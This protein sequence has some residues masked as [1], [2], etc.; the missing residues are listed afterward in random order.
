MLTVH[1]LESMLGPFRR[2]TYETPWEQATV[3]EIVH[4]HRLP[5]WPP[6]LPLFVAVN[7]KKVR[8]LA[9]LDDRPPDGSFVVVAPQFQGPAGFAIPL[10]GKVVIAFV[11]SVFAFGIGRSLARKQKP[12][13]RGS[14]QYGFD[15]VST[16]QGQGNKKPKGYGRMVVGGQVAQAALIAPDGLIDREELLVVVSFGE[17]RWHSIGGETG[18]EAGEWDPSPF[19]DGGGPVGITVNGI[20]IDPQSVSLRMGTLTQSVFP[21]I[22]FGSSV[23][24]VGATLNDQTNGDAQAPVVQLVTESI[25]R[26]TCKLVFPSGLYRVIGGNSQPVAVTFRV[27]WRP[28]A[29]IGQSGG[30][31]TAEPDFTVAPAQAT[32][33]RFAFNKSFAIPVATPNGVD[34]RL[35]RLTAKVPDPGVGDCVWQQVQHR[36]DG[37]FAHPGHVMA[38][39]RFAA[40]ETTDTFGENIEVRALAEMDRVTLWDPVL[41]HSTRSYYLQ[42]ELHDPADPFAGK[43]TFAPGRNPAWIAHRMLTEPEGSLQAVARD[44]TIRMQDVF[45]FATWCDQDDGAGQPMFTCDILF[46]E[47]IGGFDAL[48]RVCQVAR[49]VPAVIGDEIRFFYDFR[50]AHGHVTARKV[51]GQ[52]A[53]SSM[54][55]FR[56]R[57]LDYD[58]RPALTHV[59]FQSED[60]GFDWVLIPI[61]DPER[62]HNKPY[63]LDFRPIVEDTIRVQGMVRAAQVQRETL[64][65]INILRLTRSEF[66]GEGGPETFAYELNDIVDVHSE[67]FRPFGTDATSYAFRGRNDA[68]N[69]TL[70]LDREVTLPASAQVQGVNHVGTLKTVAITTGAGTYPAGTVLTLGA[71][72]TIHAEGTAVVIGETAKL[73]RPYI[74]IEIEPLALNVRRY[75]GV[76]WQPAAFDV[77]GPGLPP[78]SGPT[79]DPAPDGTLTPGVPEVQT[80]TLR[81]RHEGHELTWQGADGGTGRRV[82]VFARRAGSA[83]SRLELLGA[84]SGRALVTPYLEPHRDYEMVV[85]PQ[86]GHGVYRSPEGTTP[87]VVRAQEFPSTHVATP[88]GF[89]AEIVA[90]GIRF[91]WE[92]VEHFDLHDYEI[93]VGPKWLGGQVVLRTGVPHALLTDPWSSDGQQFML[94]A[95]TRSGMVSG[96]PAYVTV[97]FDRPHDAAAH[98]QTEDIAAALAGTLSAGLAYQTS[99]TRYVELTGPSGI[100]TS[101]QINA[102][103]VGRFWWSFYVDG[104]WRDVATTIG[105]LTHRIGD[106]EAAWRLVGGRPASVHKRGHD[107]DRLISDATNPIR[108]STRYCGGAADSPGD[109]GRLVP[110]IRFELPGSGWTA[111]RP[112]RSQWAVAQKAEGRVRLNRAGAK[113]DVRL[114]RAVIAAAV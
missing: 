54:R 8:E 69:L 44:Y 62:R 36:V 49:C 9:E 31:W 107:F 37:P 15:G 100:Y 91:D 65:Q 84:A 86:D 60:D 99:P 35:R 68:T 59:Q 21:E 45:D 6:G 16:T 30:G 71:T 79:A 81:R 5:E 41:G 18:G 110:E 104:W 27:E 33:G 114:T 90:G 52:L 101:P 25:D 73:C 78:P 96:R 106:G 51:V 7:G 14:G 20:A 63:S 97:D 66:L 77:T 113:Y 112:A 32:F 3:D 47:S 105:E 56:Q 89:R 46:D 57:R 22:S 1:V 83:G 98:T 64:Y 2:R 48:R 111:W 80:I 39:I 109:W 23:E 28:T 92:P 26:V 82:K 42:P 75:R 70:V 76:E 24:V 55:N 50:D 10:I 85:A 29:P 94:R 11:A 103:I 67:A 43:W 19:P 72:F 95:R 88:Q 4:R 17:G 53:A 34:V 87:I 61:E 58:D 93:R 102:G 38:A 12:V 13:Q 108:E 40:T 74:L